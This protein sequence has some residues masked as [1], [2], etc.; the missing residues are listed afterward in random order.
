M[1]PEE[2]AILIM[3]FSFIGTTIHIMLWSGE[4]VLFILALIIVCFLGI[5]NLFIIYFRQF[6]NFAEC[7]IKAN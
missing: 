4:L 1:K 5:R 3:F 6:I 2:L 7:M